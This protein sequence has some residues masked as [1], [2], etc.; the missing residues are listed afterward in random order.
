MS[1]VGLKDLAAVLAQRHSL[2]QDAADRFLSLMLEVLNDGLRYEKLVKIKG[3]G[4]FKVQSVSARKSVDVNTGEPIEIAGREKISY[5]PDAVM[6]DLV[7][8]PFASF[9]T[10]VLDD[11]VDLSDLDEADAGIIDSVDEVDDEIITI[12]NLPVNAEKE[13]TIIESEPDDTPDGQVEKD[14][15]PA[16]TV[17]PTA[18]PVLEEN[19][20]GMEERALATPLLDFADTNDAEEQ[21]E[22]QEPES[23]IYE[24]WTE[25]RVNAENKVLSSANELLREQVS[26]FKHLT[27]I[28]GIAAA[29]LLLLFIGASFYVSNQLKQRDNRIEHLL[30]QIHL[31]SVKPHGSAWTAEREKKQLESAAP[32]SQS[33]EVQASHQSVSQPPVAS[34]ASA[35]KPAVVKNTAA[36][37]QKNSLKPVGE[38]EDALGTSQYNQDPRVRTGAYNIIGID[39]IVTVRRGQTLKSISRNYLGPGMECYVEAVNGGAKELKEGEKIK[40]PKLKIK[41]K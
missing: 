2:S 29:V 37:N 27:N 26:Q 7:N 24:R 18:D 20:E 1:K 5:T 25:D 30:T 4:T 38:K 39:Q 41:K 8:R 32:T 11:K 40:I 12:D 35:K 31:N 14:V 21:M 22:P 19:R 23:K 9:E 10:I 34:T 28:F 36:K 15:S 6:R 17:S 13:S 16:A 3:L 33:K